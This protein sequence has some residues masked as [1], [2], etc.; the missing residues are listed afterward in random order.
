MLSP[1]SQS[2]G[3]PLHHQAVREGWGCVT[4]ARAH[5]PRIVAPTLPFTLSSSWPPCFP[6][7]R[8]PPSLADRSFPTRAF[9]AYICMCVRRSVF[10]RLCSERC[11]A[12]TRCKA[13]LRGRRTSYVTTALPVS[14]S[15]LALHRRNSPLNRARAMNG[16]RDTSKNNWWVMLHNTE[17]DNTK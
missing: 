7:L 4:Q 13:G 17:R 15:Y 11:G 5:S 9:H 2:N 3:F 14:L 10:V 8:P 16:K 12:A 6:S 1:T